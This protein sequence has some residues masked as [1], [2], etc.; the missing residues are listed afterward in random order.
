MLD[1]YGVATLVHGALLCISPPQWRRTMNMCCERRVRF[2]SILLELTHIHRSNIY[3]MRCSTI[4]CLCLY[5]FAV[6]CCFQ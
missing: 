2:P 6:I 5:L 3:K 4:V 1:I